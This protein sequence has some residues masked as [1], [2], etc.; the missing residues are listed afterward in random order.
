MRRGWIVGIGLVGALG[1]LGCGDDEQADPT[2][3]DVAQTPEETTG[4]DGPEL[5]DDATEFTLPD[6]GDGEGRVP[7]PDGALS[8]EEAREELIAGGYDCGDI[9][10]YEVAD[11][12]MD[13]GVAP[14]ATFGCDGPDGAIEVIIAADEVEVGQLYVLVE[15]AACG[16]EPE[17]VLTGEGRWLA[18]PRDEGAPDAIAAAAEVLGTDLLPFECG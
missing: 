3:T 16:F 17:L 11:D 8:P 10:T 12:E 18:G 15:S 13:L 2:T 1:L 14:A 5:G 7:S 9:E 4:D 6:L